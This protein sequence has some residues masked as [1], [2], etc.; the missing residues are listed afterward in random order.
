MPSIR[1]PERRRHRRVRMKQGLRVRPSNPKDPQ[2]EE[3]GTTHDVS[4]DGLYFVTE[5]DVYVEGMRLFV[6]V[7]YHTP[8]SPQNYH[9]LGQV[10]RVDSLQN[11]QKGV[12]IKFLSSASKESPQN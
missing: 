5:R 11:N 8:N 3:I 4:Q 2:F 7:P 10:A 6:T 9:Y 12:A 1:Q